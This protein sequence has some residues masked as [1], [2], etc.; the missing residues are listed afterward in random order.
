M[1]A[2]S[3]QKIIML[4]QTLAA[5]FHQ[6][7]FLRREFIFLS[8]R[9]DRC[10][11]ND[12]GLGTSSLSPSQKQVQITNSDSEEKESETPKR[13]FPKLGVSSLHQ[14]PTNPL[15]PP[16][17]EVNSSSSSETEDSIVEEKVC[18]STPQQSPTKPEDYVPSDWPEDLPLPTVE[19]L[20]Y[21]GIKHQTP[22]PSRFTKNSKKIL[23][24]FKTRTSTGL[25][26]LK[27]TVSDMMK[28]E[29]EEYALQQQVFEK[30]TK[31]AADE[32]DFSIHMIKEASLQR[33]AET[34]TS[35]NVTKEKSQMGVFPPSGGR[36]RETEPIRCRKL[37][38]NE[39][40]R[41]G[42]RNRL[43]KRIDVKSQD[44]MKRHRRNR[45]MIS[46]VRRRVHEAHKRV[47]IDET[48]PKTKVPAAYRAD[49]SK[50][51]VYT[52]GGQV[53]QFR[54]GELDWNYLW[55][56]SDS[57][58]AT[59]NS[60]TNS[61]NPGD[62]SLLTANQ[63]VISNEFSSSSSSTTDSSIIEEKSTVTPPPTA[64][65]SPATRQKKN[66]S[67]QPVLRHATKKRIRKLAVNP[68]SEDSMTLLGMVWR[69]NF[70]IL[71]MLYF[72]GR[73]S[74]FFFLF[75][76]IVHQYFNYDKRFS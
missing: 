41:S 1:R 9:L 27:T 72:S 38:S 23:S 2:T 4:C 21:P 68:P 58:S 64:I 18:T 76:E 75:S 71:P 6:I 29:R 25:L 14:K 56:F 12:S 40:I 24:G 30:I 37:R 19:D 50:Q 13:R 16:P 46:E 65:G 63:T 36:L 61:S 70:F 55:F 51:P 15:P 49:R 5:L 10:S 47:Q 42:S 53:P 26:K 59:T 69:L 34:A 11:S 8:F 73:F 52:R 33:L 17:V 66:Q 28:S 20:L 60:T 7:F 32:D 74:S 44:D 48:S 67:P 45:K 39:R 31:T 22:S 43:K 35:N 57:S 54:N 62:M 3:S